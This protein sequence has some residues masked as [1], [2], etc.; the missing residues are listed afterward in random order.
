MIH[1]EWPWLLAAL[2]L[3]LIV[4]WLFP[5]NKP[6]E[7]AALKVPFL[8]DLSDVE[9]RA[10]A[11]T[12][13]WPLLL[14][15][16]AWLLLV[17]ACTRPQW[18]GEPIEQAV[19]GRDLMLAVD[20]S[21]SMEEQDFVINKRAVDRLTAAKG[22]AG[23]FINR[24]VGD[25]VGLIL[26]GTQAYLQTPLTFDRKTV[27]TL[28]NEAVIGLAGD[29]TAIGD[30]IGLAVKRLENEQ[31]NSRV[32]V[33]MT[34]GANTAGEVSPLKAAE[35]AAA[36]HLK[37]YTIGIG[38]DEMIVRSFFGNRKVNPS[39]DLDE[40]TLIKIAEMT[41]GQYYRARNTDELNNIYMRLD[42]LEPVEKDKQYFRP[43]SE[44]YFW[45]LSLA[46]G[47]ATVIALS[48]V[49]L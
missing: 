38:A 39:V 45:P 26:F 14:A 41:G 33:L 11:Q 34:D 4:R 1:F 28:L 23:D 12:Q 31:A 7:Q 47:L 2:P 36:N 22:V 3:P 25:R 13:A 10:V 20:L 15:A 5:A 32:L 42:E 37:I 24:R 6:A 8:D 21:G 46:L 49:R 30:A 35:L 44:L 43:R 19:S 18:L 17:I 40:K 16:L 48:K 27:M 29:N 9:T